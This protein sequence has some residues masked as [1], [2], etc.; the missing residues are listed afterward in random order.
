MLACDEI[1]KLLVHVRLG[2]LSDI[3]SGIGTNR[4]ERLHRKIRKWLR[5]SHIGVCLAVA[6][7]STIFYIH[8]EKSGKCVKGRE[9]KMVVPVAKW[10]SNFLANDGLLS[11][12]KFGLSS[13]LNLKIMEKEIENISDDGQPLGNHTHSEDDSSDDAN[14]D[15][16]DETENFAKV[17][18]ESLRNRTQAMTN[19]TTSIF[20]KAK[21]PIT[22]DKN[23]WIFL[24]SVLLLFSNPSFQGSE[25]GEKEESVDGLLKCY[26]FKRR[27][28]AG[29]VDC[30]FLAVAIGIEAFLQDGSQHALCTHLNALGFH[31]GQNISNQVALL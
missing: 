17:N 24:Q 4:N 6:L 3:P 21:A 28:V 10:Y 11:N 9:S 18:S 14:S 7:L 23:S 26:G 30:C 8:M 5:R 29:N 1:E 27:Q 12:E 16:D 19:I 2:C 25:R 31:I 20:S 13:N 22:A 15:N